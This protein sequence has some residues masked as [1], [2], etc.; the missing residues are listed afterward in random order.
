MKKIISSLFIVALLML[1]SCSKGGETAN[2][3]KGNTYIVVGGELLQIGDRVQFESTYLV[4][5]DIGTPYIYSESHIAFMYT[6]KQVTWKYAILP[7]TLIL[8]DGVKD[9]LLK[10]E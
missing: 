5:D 8:S 10:K 9:A 6:D 1:T 2:L 4:I 3:L 7:A